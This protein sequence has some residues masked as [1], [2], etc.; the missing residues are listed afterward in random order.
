[1]NKIWK[2]SAILLLVLFSLMV[3]ASGTTQN[4]PYFNGERMGPGARK[5]RF[6]FNMNQKGKAKDMISFDKFDKNKDGVI[7][8][9]EFKAVQ[10]IMIKMGKT[11]MK[12]RQFISGQNSE[13]DGL[14]KEYILKKYDINKNG[15]LDTKEKELIKKDRDILT[16][17]C[18]K[19]NDGKLSK[20]EKKEMF[21]EFMKQLG[22]PENEFKKTSK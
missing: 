8:K 12:I 4:T 5:N 7:D 6:G 13:H 17:I 2:E 9:D 21:K 10:K 16:K 3:Y 1:M 15:K 14:L 20:D 11:L 19:D 18:D 22:V